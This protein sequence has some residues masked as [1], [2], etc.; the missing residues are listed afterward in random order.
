MLSIKDF[1]GM[2][3]PRNA[4]CHVLSTSVQYA[5]VS[6]LSC[7]HSA[8]SYVLTWLWFCFQNSLYIYIVCFKTLV[9]DKL[10]LRCL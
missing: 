4:S 2:N 3:C 6:S 8:Q 10:N 9:L 7:G 5:S 1:K